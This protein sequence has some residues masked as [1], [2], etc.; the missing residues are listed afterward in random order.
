MA[1]TADGRNDVYERIKKELPEQYADFGIAESNMIAAAAGM[2][3][4]G[5]IP[6]IFGMT[7]FL[8]Y[9]AFEFIRNDVC[10]NAQ[11]VKFLAIFSG[12]ARGAWGATHQGTEDLAILRTLPNLLVVTPATPNEARAATRFAYEHDGPVYIRLESSNEPE[13]FPKDNVFQPG[14]G[15]ILRDGNDVAVIAMGSVVNVAL[16]AAE[17]LDKEGISLHVIELPT[18]RPIDTQIIC[19]AADATKGI[20]TLEEQTIFGGLGSAVA[21]VLAEHQK[22]V[23][24]RRIGLDGFARG[25]GNQSE[26]REQ[27]GLDKAAVIQEVRDIMA[28]EEST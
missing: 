17:Q 4:C 14:R 2:A 13:H 26:L 19:R 16:A 28:M 8:A 11:N 18:V 3:S 5:Q 25:C 22:R 6:F 7:T 24:F 20:L 12:I 10:F 15:H 1:L 23:P 27:N 21:E 9:R